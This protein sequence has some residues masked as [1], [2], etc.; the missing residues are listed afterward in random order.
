MSR[1]STIARVRKLD[2]ASHGAFKLFFPCSN[3]SPREAVSGGKPYP[4]KSKAVRALILA[5]SIKG[6]CDRLEPMTLGKICRNIIRPWPAPILLAAQTY[7]RLLARKNSARTID[8]SV[9]Q[10]K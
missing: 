1:D 7:S 4:K 6:S 2:Q 5:V 8:T 10:P 9:V 3:S